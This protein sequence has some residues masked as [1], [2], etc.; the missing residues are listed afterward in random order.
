MHLSL[1]P[2]ETLSVD[3]DH[4]KAIERLIVVLYDRTSPLNLVNDTRDELFCKKKRTTER[5]PPTQDALLSMSE[6]QFIKQ[7][8]GVPVSK[9]SKT[10]LHQ[11]IFL[12]VNNQTHGIQFGQLFQK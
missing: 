4:F 8:L 5:V 6:G 12:G 3:S 9:H 2:F 11:K 1:H 7:E 10:F